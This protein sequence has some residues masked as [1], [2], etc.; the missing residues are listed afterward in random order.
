[1]LETVQTHT[2]THTHNKGKNAGTVSAVRDI[3][4]PLFMILQCILDDHSVKS[5]AGDELGKD[6]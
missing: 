6:G 2:H 3:S 5:N 4:S 1:M